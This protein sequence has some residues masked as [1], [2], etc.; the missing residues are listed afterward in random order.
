MK[1]ISVLGS[2]GSIGTQALEV[3]EKEGYRVKALAAGKNIGLAE[4]QA[5][6]FKPEIVAMFDEKAAS[7]LKN[8]AQRHR[9]KGRIRRRGCLLCCSG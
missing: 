5:R 1:S 8:K 9:Y 2:T 3:A 6:L 4:N 7:D